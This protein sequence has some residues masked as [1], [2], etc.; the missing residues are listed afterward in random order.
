[1]ADLGASILV[2]ALV[3]YGLRALPLVL[4]DRPLENR[5]VTSFLHYVPYAVLTAMTIP[6]MLLA[7]SSVWSGVAGLVVACALAWWGRPLLTVAVG[8]AAAVWVVEALLA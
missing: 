6:A 8:A 5:F 4:L 2:M 1:M 7:T 3:T